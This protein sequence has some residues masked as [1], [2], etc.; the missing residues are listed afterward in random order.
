MA[1]VAEEFKAIS[2]AEFFYKNKEIAGFSNPARALYQ[3]IR[4]LIENSLDATENYGILPAVKLSI[5]ELEVVP[6]GAYYEVIVE[7]NGIGIPP[8]YVP[9]AFAQLLFSSK[10]VLKQSRGMFGLGAKMAVLYSQI[11]TGQPAEIVVAPIKSKHIHSF[12]LKIDIAE[13]KPVVLGFSVTSNITGRHGTTV[14]L[15]TLGDWSRSKQR[16][17]EYIK[18]TAIIAPYAEIVLR[19]PDGNY[20]YFERTIDKLPPPARETLPHPHG[21]DIETM[22][23]ILRVEVD[24]PLIETLI[25]NFQGV[26]YTTALRILEESRLNPDRKSGELSDSEIEVLVRIMRSYKD[27]KPPRADHISYLGREIITAGLRKIFE[28]EFVYAISRRPSV[29]E[30]HAFIVEVGIAY[31]GKVPI[32]ERPLVLRYANKIPLLYDEGSDVVFKIL[33]EKK[34]IDFKTYE[35]EFPAPLVI[36]TH[37]CSTK[38]PYKGV[39]KE[40]VADVPEIEEEIE[41]AL[42]EALRE[43]RSYILKKRKEIEEIEKAVAIA[44]YIPEVASSLAKM[45]KVDPQEISTKLLELLNSRLKTFKIPSLHNIVV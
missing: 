28:P 44:K 9:Q 2:P 38:I 34:V 39:G 4:E 43:L 42:R 23:S 16:V 3:T 35:I 30:G 7:D 37:I 24:K 19:D 29:Y 15:V 11:T 27:I 6:E 33:N 14:K 8:K 12:R 41:S 45:Y 18:R 32:A 22:K 36:L 13:N 40:A 31:G 5:R 10:Y 17:Y 25:E 20:L 26:G 1:A 21:I